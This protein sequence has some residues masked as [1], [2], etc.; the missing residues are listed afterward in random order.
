MVSS[1]TKGKR[2]FIR[3][4]RFL[5]ITSNYDKSKVKLI[6]LNQPISKHALINLY[7][8]TS[9]V[10]CADGGSNRLYDVFNNAGDRIKYK[11]HAIV[12]DLDSLRPDVRNF[13]EDVGTKVIKVDN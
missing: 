1:I 7:S 4:N 11:P 9:M 5:D 6:L 10:V 12:G 2:I 13:Y 8:K 3:D